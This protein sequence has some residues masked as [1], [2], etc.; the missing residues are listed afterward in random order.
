MGG[1][2][3]LLHELRCRLLHGHLQAAA[4]GNRF[5]CGDILLAEDGHEDLAGS[6]ALIV[7]D[8]DSPVV[9]LEPIGIAAAALLQEQAKTLHSLIRQRTPARRTDGWA[10]SIRLTVASILVE[11]TRAPGAP[12]TT[13]TESIARGAIRYL[14]NHFRRAVTMDHLAEEV[15]CSRSRLFAIFKQETGMSPNDW[16]LRRG[17]KIATEH[18]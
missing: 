1:V 2:R 15:G 9:R 16:L 12:R 3:S 17:V 5:A 4:V 13:S 6:T 14:D 8:A 7:H 18:R 11:A 10:G